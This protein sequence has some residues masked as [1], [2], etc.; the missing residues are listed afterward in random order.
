[1]KSYDNGDLLTEPDGKKNEE[2]K[3]EQA[4]RLRPKVKVRDLSA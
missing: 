3:H 1:M 4:A 2:K